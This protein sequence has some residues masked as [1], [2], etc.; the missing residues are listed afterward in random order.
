MTVW[1]SGLDPFV[2]CGA[3]YT[4]RYNIRPLAILAAAKADNWSEKSQRRVAAM[5]NSGAIWFGGS[6]VQASYNPRAT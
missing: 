1:E 3:G 6:L 5:V 4:Y 2:P